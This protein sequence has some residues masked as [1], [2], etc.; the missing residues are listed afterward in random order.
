MAIEQRQRQA[1]VGMSDRVFTP[2][3][4]TAIT[5]SWRGLLD[6]PALPPMSQSLQRPIEEC[7]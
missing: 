5:P 1:V 3:L 6:T 4:E 2:E 7:S